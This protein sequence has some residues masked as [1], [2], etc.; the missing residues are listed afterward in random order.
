MTN[1][2]FTDDQSNQTVQQ[3]TPQLLT[4]FEKVLSPP[5][6]QLEDEAREMVKRTVQG[7]Y[8]AQPSL[9]ANH[10]SLL[11]LAGAQ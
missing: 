5:E 10:Q 3:F 6:E 7:L 9:F 4:I 2:L 8:K 1:I 11:S